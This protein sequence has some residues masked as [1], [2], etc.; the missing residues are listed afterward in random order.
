MT[1]LWWAQ[2]KAVIRLEMRK[3]FFARRGLWIYVLAL[4][5]LL[6][7]VAHAVIVS[8]EQGQ[9]Q[10]MA[11]RS[12][13]PLTSQDLSAIKTGMT[14]DEVIALLGKPPVRV[15]W[16]QRKPI[17]VTNAVAGL[18]G[19]GTPVNLSA[20]YNLTGIYADGTTFNDDGLDGA[21]F[22]YSSN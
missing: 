14:R 4:L 21:G 9:N 12:E 18:G 20:A 15:H 1:K 16:N 3:T 5:P 8:H 22:G 2:V 11:T 6:L 7:F 10:E 19:A 17:R 13:K